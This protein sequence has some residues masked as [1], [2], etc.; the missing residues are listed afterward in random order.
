MTCP[1]H[2]CICYMSVPESLPAHTGSRYPIVL[3]RSIVT[4]C[5]RGSS[6]M[7]SVQPCPVLW[8]DKPLVAGSCHAAQYMPCSLWSCSGTLQLRQRTAASTQ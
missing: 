3:A 7:G 4:Y 6:T 8:Q 1:Y 5:R 2:L